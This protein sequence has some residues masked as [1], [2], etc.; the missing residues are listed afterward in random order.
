[1]EFRLS[2]IPRR[3]VVMHDMRDT[4]ELREARKSRFSRAR[5]A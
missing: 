1:M 3:L 5:R 4:G 2:Y